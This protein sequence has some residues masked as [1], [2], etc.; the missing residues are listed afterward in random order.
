[1]E[2]IEK[3]VTRRHTFFCVNRARHTRFSSNVIEVVPKEIT[4]FGQTVKGWLITSE[5][6]T[7]DK[8]IT[9]Q[10]SVGPDFIFHD[11]E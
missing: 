11:P 4:V 10:E 5:E 1:M 6:P 7:I 8:L 3:G 2:F 9:L